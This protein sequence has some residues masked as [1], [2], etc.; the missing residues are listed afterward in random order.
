MRCSGMRREG[1]MNG[2]PYFQGREEPE[3]ESKEVPISKDGR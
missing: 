2:I 3:N 1:E